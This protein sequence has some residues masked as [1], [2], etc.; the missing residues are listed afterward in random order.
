MSLVKSQTLNVLVGEFSKDDSLC[1][2]FNPLEVVDS[3]KETL[4]CQIWFHQN[5]I[6]PRHSTPSIKRKKGVHDNSDSDASF[7]IG[8]PS[9]SGKTNLSNG[10]RIVIPRNLLQNGVVITHKQA[11]SIS[12]KRPNID[13]LKIIIFSNQVLI[14]N[15][16]V[17]ELLTV[18]LN[19]CQF[20][21]LI[22][23]S[24]LGFLVLYEP[25][26]LNDG[27]GLRS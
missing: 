8:K 1:E 20:L 11:Y 15:Q 3:I 26:F 5:T 6:Q 24:G 12:C 25:Y 7:M 18:D 2:G 14:R 4:C 13:L 16:R 17:T 9:K 21:R 27:Y 22:H 19:P 23:I 10:Q